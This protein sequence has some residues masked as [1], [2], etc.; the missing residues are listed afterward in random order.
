MLYRLT[1]TLLGTWMLWAS[2]A[3]PALAYNHA[4][5]FTFAARWNEWGRYKS[6]GVTVYPEEFGN[7][8]QYDTCPPTEVSAIFPAT[9]VPGNIKQTCANRWKA[10]IESPYLMASAAQGVRAKDMSEDWILD[11]VNPNDSVWNNYFNWYV[12]SAYINPQVLR[13]VYPTTLANSGPHAGKSVI[14]NPNVLAVG[15]KLFVMLDPDGSLSYYLYGAGGNL[16]KNSTA[17]T[18][19]NG[20][21]NGKALTDQLKYMIGYEEYQ[22]YFLEGD[23]TLHVFDLDLKWV[24]TD[25]VALGNEL[26]AYTM[27]ELVDNQIPGY[28]YIGWDAGPIVV[29][30]TALRPLDH[31]Q[32][33][34]SVTSTNTGSPVTLSIS[35]CID[36]TGCA[37]AYTR[38]VSGTVTL[39]DG[40][41]Y[42]LAIPAGASSTQIAIT[43]ASQPA[44]GSVQVATANVAPTALGTPTTLCQ[45]GTNA[46]AS[47]ACLLPVANPLDHIELSGPSNGLTCAPS[48][49]TVKACGNAQC[50]TLFTGGV[51]GDLVVGGAGATVTPSSA[52]PFTIPALQSSITVSLQVTKAPASNSV[53]LS[54]SDLTQAAQAT[55]PLFCA[56]GTT[57]LAAA[58]CNFGVSTSA[59]LVSAANHVAEDAGVTVSIQAVKSNADQTACVPAFSGPRSVT[60]SCGHLD[61][62]VGARALVVNGIPLN[63][64]TDANQACD[65]NGQSLTLQFDAATGTATPSVSYGD[66]GRVNLK[67]TL[68]GAP[69]DASVGMTGQAAFTVATARFS[70]ARTGTGTLRAGEA[71]GVTLKAVTALG[72]TAPSFGSISAASAHPVTLAWNVTAPT[73]SNVQAGSLVGT[74]TAMGAVLDAS[75]FAG[76]TASVS[77]L[78]WS[79]VGT[80]TLTAAL[81][82]PGG[83]MDSGIAVQGSLAGVGPFVP[84]YFEV[85]APPACGSFSYSGQ[86]WNA[87]KVYARNAAGQTTQN[88]DGSGAMSPAQSSSVSLAVSG[89]AQ[90]VGSL[91]NGTI[92]ANRFVRGE[93]TPASAP[94]F[95]FNQKSTAPVALTIG[96]NRSDG[97]TSTATPTAS[98]G[99]RSGRL[100]I[101]S[102][103]GSEHTALQLPVT[104][105]Y[106]SGKYWVM[107]G[108]DSCTRIPVAAVAFSGF[109]NQKGQS[110]DP[111]VSAPGT[112][113]T[114]AGT[115]MATLVQAGRG[116]L[117]LAAPPSGVTGSVDVAVNLGLTAADLSCLPG[118][119]QTTGAGLPWLR[120]VGGGS[121]ACAVA[122]DRDPSA[123]A[124]FGVFSPESQKVMHVRDVY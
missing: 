93:G 95:T 77:N 83:F 89:G 15:D 110:L 68:F 50:T 51:S 117:T 5:N 121:A 9:T 112:E 87:L 91:S 111:F 39:S 108:N 3:Q 73:G 107:N 52:V 92:A 54:L 116:L 84:A 26:S 13:I 29:G 7:L 75:A 99:M 23:S 20:A 119:P 123:R 44:S 33:T 32:I 103:Y 61:P 98:M 19:R 66:V 88:F 100:R 115:A 113:A 60:L 124:T 14:N 36:T 78:S 25:T 56:L 94:A 22:L 27:G 6:G 58:S 17:T 69:T 90:T 62:A 82:R 1:C 42:A 48:V 63:A 86:G 11:F 37:N 64:T 31:L 34:S 96:V 8:W 114:V 47:A 28:T 101:G 18:F 43:V 65:A 55:Q 53:A 10:L 40:S 59:F 16:W 41:T 45:F 122:A 4:G 106:W 76:G 35:A 81:Q 109:Q 85:S 80:G 38:G 102:A 46:T 97:V 118:H 74:G 71:W 104:T 72:N 120:S 57:P 70:V 67:A 24:R 21:W 30:V 2:L 105:E 49:F 12:N 79:E